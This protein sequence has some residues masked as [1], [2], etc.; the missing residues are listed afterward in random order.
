MSLLEFVRGAVWPPGAR[1][2][3]LPC[4]FY[5]LGTATIKAPVGSY[6]QQARHGQK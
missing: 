5:S 6:Y 3:V 2:R 4:L 1:E